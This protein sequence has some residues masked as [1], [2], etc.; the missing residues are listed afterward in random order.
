MNVKRI[1]S[2]LKLIILFIL[3]PLFNSGELNAQGHHINTGLYYNLRDETI[4]LND[5]SFICFNSSDTLA[6]C[7]YIILDNNYIELFSP[8]PYKEALKGYAIK[9]NSTLID[10]DSVR[11]C[12]N[13]P[14]YDSS[15]DSLIITI[16]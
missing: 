7:S 4:N 15:T 14:N 13:L 5:S 16:S 12:F 11:L 10:S 2:K 3:I 8:D 9:Q 1:K 6:F